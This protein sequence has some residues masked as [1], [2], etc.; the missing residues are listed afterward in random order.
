RSDS[1][2]DS[3]RAADCPSAARADCSAVAAFLAIVSWF[4]IVLTGSHVLGI[5]QFTLFFMRWRVRA[6]AY[7]ML[8]EDAYPP[9]G[10]EPYP[11]SIEIAEAPGPRDRVTV[12]F[13]IILAIPQIIVLCFVMFGWCF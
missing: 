7:L 5:R 9:F 6:V 4:T 12:A 11:A 2:P 13:R 3:A 1:A 10:D 8:L